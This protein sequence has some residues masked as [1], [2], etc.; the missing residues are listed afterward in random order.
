MDE[1][2]A[3]LLTAIIDQFIETA[4]PVGS[5]RLL[6]SADFAVSSATI[7]S[8]MSDLESA[9]FLLQP[10]VSAG[11][12]PTAK[13][14]RVYV[15]EFMKPTRHEKAVRRKF[16]ELRE[17]YWQR[18]DQERVYEAIALLAHMVPNVAF[19]TV[20]H[21]ERVYYL[22]LANT[23]RQPE[24]Q[25][26]P[27]LAS[28]VVEVLEHRLHDVIRDLQLDDEVRYYIGEEHI[29]PQFQ[30]CS[31]M[32]TRYTIRGSEGAIGIM[33][34]LRMDYAYNTVALDLVANLLRSH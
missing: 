17:Q 24:F 22:G 21:K 8:E 11:R 14:Y 5:K 6:E 7:R 15:Q 10:H 2:Q 13:G 16:D 3:K 4:L 33:G 30:S 29:L 34:P 23:L 20:P 1:R 25:S 32:L 27:L 12:I 26:N 19:A 28:G 31:V 9:G 18:K